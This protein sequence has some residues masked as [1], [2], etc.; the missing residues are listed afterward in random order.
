M[1]MMQDAFTLL[2]LLPKKQAQLLPKL[3]A[4]YILQTAARPSLNF[5]IM[6]FLIIRNHLSFPI[7]FEIVEKKS[8]HK[9][10]FS[11]QPEEQTE[12]SCN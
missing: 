4:S 5:T 2:G 10:C 8:Q 9:Q 6:P 12:L 1:L 7:A 3:Y 11:L